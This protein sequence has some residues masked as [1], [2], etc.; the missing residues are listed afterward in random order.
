MMQFI[1]SI[2]IF[3]RTLIPRLKAWVDNEVSLMSWKTYSVIRE[4]SVVSVAG[5][6]LFIIYSLLTT[7]GHLNL[8]N[9]ERTQPCVKVFGQ[10]HWNTSGWDRIGEYWISRC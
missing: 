10:A 9:E 1:K 7:H 5:K 3:G 6:P 8:Q 4:W 2:A